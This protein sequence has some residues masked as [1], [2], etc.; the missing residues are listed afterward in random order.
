MLAWA[1]ARL[2]YMPAATLVAAM[3]PLAA[4]WRAPAVQVGVRG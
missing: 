1:M 2:A 4:E 3:L